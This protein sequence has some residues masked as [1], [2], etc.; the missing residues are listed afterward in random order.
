MKTALIV[1]A[2]IVA[3]AIAIG[4]A[5]YLWVSIGDVEISWIGMLALIGGSILTLMLGGGLMALVFYSS[6]R[7]HDD[8]AGH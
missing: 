6:R 8:D 4:T 3:L 5:I 1:I 2:F 7:G